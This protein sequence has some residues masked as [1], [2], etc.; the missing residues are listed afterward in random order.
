MTPASRTDHSC[1]MFS[2]IA[3]IRPDNSAADQKPHFLWWMWA[4]RKKRR[5]GLGLSRGALTFTLALKRAFNQ[6]EGSRHRCGADVH[7]RARAR[8]PFVYILEQKR[9]F[10]HLDAVLHLHVSQQFA[11]DAKQTKVSLLVVNH[12]VTLAGG[13]DES[14]LQAAVRPLQ[15][16][17]QVPIHGMDQTRTL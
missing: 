7:V 8:S 11:V 16:P 15:G 1:G 3:A 17:Q 9:T 12:A 5:G 2:T 14:G 4:N 10:P 6:R 13:L